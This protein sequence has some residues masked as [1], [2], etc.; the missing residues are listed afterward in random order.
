[1]VGRDEV[2]TVLRQRAA[3]AKWA[4]GGTDGSPVRDHRQV[5]IVNAVTVIAKSSLQYAVR[6]LRRDARAD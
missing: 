5:K 6:R 4:P 1:M 2:V 3:L